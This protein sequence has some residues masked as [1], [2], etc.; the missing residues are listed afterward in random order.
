M[1]SVLLKSVLH[2]S[3]SAVAGKFNFERR[4]SSHFTSV[5]EPWLEERTLRMLIPA[6]TAFM[7]VGFSLKSK[8]MT[9]TSVFLGTFSI[10]KANSDII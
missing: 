9:N 7:S 8:A 10:L 4:V 3:P 1:R 2:F 6:L 5:S